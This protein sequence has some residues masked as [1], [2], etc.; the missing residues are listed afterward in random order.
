MGEGA[1]M[2]RAMSLI[3][4]LAAAV[5]VALSWR[6]E[7]L[8]AGNVFDGIDFYNGDEV[9]AWCRSSDPRDQRACEAYICGVLDAWSMQYTVLHTTPYPYCLPAGTTCKHLIKL[10]TD[11]VTKHPDEGKGAGDSAVGYPLSEIFPC[12]ISG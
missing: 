1:E 4:A 11:E 2:K 12:L 9:Y 10:L 6:A 3:L 8:N 7:T 5:C